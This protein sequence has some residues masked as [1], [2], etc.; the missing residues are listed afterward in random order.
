M[1][2]RQRYPA[3]HEQ[4]VVLAQ[5]ARDGGL[6]FDVWWDAAVRPGRPP[7]TWRTD[8]AFR[9]GGCVVWPN[10][11]ADRQV[12]LA[13]HGDPVVVEAWRRAYDRLPATRRDSALRLLAPVLERA[14]ARDRSLAPA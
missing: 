11:T 12:A 6:S 13:V 8:P 2:A 14:Q 4:L 10:D 7:V 9:P 1:A 5:A 3:V